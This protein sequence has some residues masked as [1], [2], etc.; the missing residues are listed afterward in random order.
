MTTPFIVHLDA[1][2]S[3]RMAHALCSGHPTGRAQPSDRYPVHI[4]R[5][6]TGRWLQLLAQALTEIGPELP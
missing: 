6:C 5:A 1:T 2:P 4:C 3:D